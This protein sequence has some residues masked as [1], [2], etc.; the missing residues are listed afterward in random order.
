M[1]IKN[2]LL[3]NNGVALVL[4]V[5]IAIVMY[6]SINKLI[7]SSMDV[8]HTHKTIR[9]GNRLMASM[10]DQET[11]M[12]GYLVSGNKDYLEPYDKGK[13]VFSKKIIE[14]QQ[15]V[16]DTPEH[17]ESGDIIKNIRS[18]R[19]PFCDF[20]LRSIVPLIRTNSLS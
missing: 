3:L 12:R 14:I 6:V 8:E 10:L 15:I 9:L 1:N 5:F 19:T 4:I 18:Y 11:G 20:F 13:L 17:T 7:Q 16:S 2:K